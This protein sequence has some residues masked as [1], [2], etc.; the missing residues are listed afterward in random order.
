MGCIGLRRRG[1]ARRLF[2]SGDLPDLINES[3]FAA[4]AFKSDQIAQF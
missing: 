1:V 3:R 2:D 4:H